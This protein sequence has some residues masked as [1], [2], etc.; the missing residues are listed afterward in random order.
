M[1]SGLTVPPRRILMTLD[2]VGGL[3]RYG[4]DLCRALHPHGLRFVLVGLGPRPSEAQRREAEELPNAELVWLDAPL[5]WLATSESDL[6]AL[7]GQLTDLVQRFEIDILHLNLPSQAAGLDIGRPVVVVSHSCVV[8]WWAAVRGTDLP[9]EWRWQ[10]ARNRAG[11][12]AADAV[13]APSESHARQLRSCYGPIERLSVIP[14][15][16]VAA[17]RPAAKEPFVF[18]AGRWWDDGKNGRVLDEAARSTRWPVL[19]AGSCRSAAGQ[20][21]AIQHARALGEL[22]GGEVKDLMARAGIVVSPSLYEPF[23]LAALEGAQ[24]EAALVLAD[25]PTYRGFWDG[26][27]LFA[28]PRHP[29][30]F[31]D[32]IDTLSGDPDLRADFGRRAKI[33]AGRFSP[34]AQAEAVLSAYRTAATRPSRQLAAAE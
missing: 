29:E 24:A 25:I 20:S 8:T 14:N 27:A 21:F 30:A 28:D 9:A 1:A 17:L 34:E 7:P 18:A 22:A 31:S 3:W 33:R 2:A 12:D 5:D 6:D 4:V 13:L 32:A 11:F 16:S 23:G 19:M 10:Q 15:A 26:V